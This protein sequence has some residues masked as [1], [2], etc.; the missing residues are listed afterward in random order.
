MERLCSKWLKNCEGKELTATLAT[1]R[2]DTP[3]TTGTETSGGCQDAAM[4]CI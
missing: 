3:N 2:K 1:E 4:N